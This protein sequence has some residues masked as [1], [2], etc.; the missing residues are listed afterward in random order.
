MDIWGLI[1]SD[2][3]N[4]FFPNLAAAFQDQMLQHSL[5]AVIMTAGWDERRT[6]VCIKR[7]LN[8]RVPAIALMTSLVDESVKE[9]L[10]ESKICAAYLDL[11][12]VGDGRQVCG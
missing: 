7:L 10:I 3:R 9:M 11:G 2:I 1:I 5:D 4:P 8:L 12:R 6:L